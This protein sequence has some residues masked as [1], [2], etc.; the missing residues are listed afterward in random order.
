[1][2]TNW[3]PSGMSNNG[4]Y[5]CKHG[6]PSYNCPLCACL[7]LTEDELITLG[8]EEGGFIR[9]IKKVRER[10]GLDLMRAKKAVEED[11]LRTG[12]YT[13]VM[14]STGCRGLDR[15]E[16]PDN[17]PPPQDSPE[18]AFLRM[19]LRYYE[20]RDK[21]PKGWMDINRPSGTDP[22]TASTLAHTITR[23]QVILNQRVPAAKKVAELKA[24]LKVV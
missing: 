2:N 11:A 7:N 5:L 15:R 16:N 6:N 14:R 13:E 24:L 9:A 21:A 20:N 23:A 1:M 12:L 19:W 17:T 18:V 8:T 4:I 22:T 10:T 3:K